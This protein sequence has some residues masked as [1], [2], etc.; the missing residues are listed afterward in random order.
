LN[1]KLTLQTKRKQW[2]NS[3]LS[4]HFA[5]FIILLV[6]VMV[7][8][9][10]IDYSLNNFKAINP[11]NVIICELNTPELALKFDVISDQVKQMP[12]VIGT[13]GSSFIPPFN[14]TLP[15]RLRDHEN[16]EDIVFDGLIMGKGMTELLDIEMVEGNHFEDFNSSETKLIFNE[17]AAAKYNFKAGTYF[18][19]FY[20]QG[21]AKDFTAHSMRNI[22]NPMV[23]IQQHPSKMSLFAIKTRGETDDRIKSDV[24]KLFKKISP[25]KM[26]VIYTLKEQISQFYIRENNQSKLISAFSIL[27][28]FLSLMGLLGIVM[29]TVSRRSKEIAI[30]KVNGANIKELL[31]MLNMEYFKWILIAFVMATPVSYYV[32]SKWLESFAYKTDISWW[33]FALAG[34]GSMIIALLAVSGLTYKAAR[35]NPVKSLRH[36]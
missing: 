24:R 23:I 18:N 26:V 12:G 13:A 14:W 36:E 32:M 6:G 3:F 34:L 22:I 19:N 5:I 17:S 9:K 8:K 28:I 10:Q 30:R 1:R 16:N 27:A 7:L 21:I 29:N 33:I 31:L 11:E 20:I 2:T 25:D 15:I 35:Q 4:L